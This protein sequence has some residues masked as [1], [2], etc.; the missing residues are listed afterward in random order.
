MIVAPYF[1]AMSS[2]HWLRVIAKT[3]SA[4]LMTDS[5]VWSRPAAPWPITA[6]VSPGVILIFSWERKTVAKAISEVP[7]S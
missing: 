4:P 5:L 2:F 1:F 7:S 6:T 3:G